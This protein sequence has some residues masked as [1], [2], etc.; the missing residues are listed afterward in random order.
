M[1][2]H[3]RAVTGVAN[4]IAIFPFYWLIRY[5][6]RQIMSLISLKNPMNLSGKIRAERNGGRKK[7]NVKFI[8]KHRRF[9][10]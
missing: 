10:V 5:S 7:F 3:H 8:V 9:F 4:E 1:K 2:R 6:K